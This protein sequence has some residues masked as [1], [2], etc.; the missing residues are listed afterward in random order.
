M[1]PLKYKKSSR[2]ESKETEKPRRTYEV[3]KAVIND[4]FDKQMEEIRN[5][6]KSGSNELQTKMKMLSK[7]I[8]TATEEAKCREMEEKRRVTTEKASGAF[9][10]AEEE[11]ARWKASR[12]AEAAREY[13]KIEAEKHLKRKKI[14]IAKPT[15]E[16][17]LNQEKIEPKR[18]V[19]RWKP[20]PPDP[21]AVIPSFSCGPKE[22]AKPKTVPPESK[23]TSKPTTPTARRKN[24]SPTVTRDTVAV[25]VPTGTTGV[26]II[27]KSDGAAATR[28]RNSAM[29]AAPITVPPPPASTV[30]PTESP[31]PTS[32]RYSSRRKTQEIV[33]ESAVKPKSKRRTEK[34]R[35][36]RFIREDRDADLML[37]FQKDSTFEQL[38]RFFE[39]AGRNRRCLGKYEKIRR[40]TP[41]KI[42]ISDLTDIDKIY[43]SSEIRD[44]IASWTVSVLGCVLNLL[45]CYVATFQ[46]PLL[47]R[48]YSI[49]TLNF[50]VTNSL[51]C[52]VNFLLQVRLISIGRTMI[53][54]AYGPISLLG[55]KA[56]ELG[57]YLYCILIHLYTHA[58]WL[59]CVSFGYRFR[60]LTRSEL[61]RRAMHFLLFLVYLPSFI[62]CILLIFEFC[63]PEI[64]R[65]KLE[66][67]PFDYSDVLAGPTIFGIEDT[68]GWKSLCTVIHVTV[69]SSPIVVCIF[70]L[71]RK[72]ITKLADAQGASKLGARTTALQMQFLRALTFQSIIPI[73]YIIGVGA[74]FLC[75]FEIYRAPFLEY[76]LFSAFLMVPVLTPVSY[77]VFVTPYRRWMIKTMRM[78]WKT[79]STETQSSRVGTRVQTVENK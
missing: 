53:F 60:V 3:V 73:F 7:G 4:D 28:I 39:Q 79:N 58:M 47:I 70:V 22:A 5:Q 44:I 45:L 9:G 30:M 61:P 74:F 10:K 72:I 65:E 12:D 15:G 48:T 77:F 32:K 23:P 54:V 27:P 67:H 29:T 42:F 59:L 36:K 33:N 64:L 71:R 41:S 1:F 51:L 24:V 31:K 69:L 13:A 25:A 76:L 16:T 46:S 18:T 68:M 26:Q 11:K 57:E 66:T 8:L 37:G 52:A 56:A 62:Q 2:L 20:P 63:D 55:N 35:K 40:L 50:A 75:R 38:E 34:P 17:V 43:K 6:M 21:N 49:L 19:R 78:E 14:L